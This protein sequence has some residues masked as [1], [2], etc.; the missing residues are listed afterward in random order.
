MTKEQQEQNEQ[1]VALKM[2]DKMITNFKTFIVKILVIVFAGGIIA[3][4]PNWFN[5]QARLA[6]LE[7]ANIDSQKQI[8]E[9]KDKKADKEV[10]EL[11][12]KNIDRQLADIK[13]DIK[14]I[15]NKK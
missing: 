6:A 14:D 7:K 1:D 12:I 9:L 3:F 15:K 2:L 10:Y 4:V 11:T 8:K 13:S 5:N